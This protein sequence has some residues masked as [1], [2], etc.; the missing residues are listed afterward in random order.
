MAFFERDRIKLYYEE[1]GDGFPVLLFAPGGPRSAVSFWEDGPFNPI[2][3]LAPHFRVIAMDQR[4][5][6]Q[7]MAPV[8]ADD[9]WHSYTGDHL[10][11]L[12]HL[13]IERTHV[14]GACIGGP[15]CLGLMQTV[16]DRVTAGVLQQTIGLDN[17]REIFYKMFQTWADDIKSDHPEADDAAWK[18]FKSNMYD[19]D[20]DFNVGREF[21]KHCTVP[22]LVLMGDDA[23]HP[24]ITSRTIAEIAPNAT[25]VEQWKAPE[26]GAVGKIVE[27]LIANTPSA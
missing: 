14:M 21:V 13:G 24:Q 5:A 10:A 16:P 3:E 18:S 27:F 1:H 9:G 7:S 19:G 11:L 25:L 23:Y 17:N 22:M 15:Y 12:D 6:G 2:T 26:D 8:S 20:L 4:N